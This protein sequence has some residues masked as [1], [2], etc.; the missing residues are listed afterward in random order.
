MPVT[1]PDD[2]NICQKWK[3]FCFLSQLALT[4]EILI[5]I[6]YWT[7]IYDRLKGTGNANEIDHTVPFIL[8]LIDYVF[9]QAVPFEW[10]HTLYVL[11]VGISYFLL[12]MTATLYA[13]RELY[14][15]VDFKSASGVALPFGLMFGGF[16]IYLV[17]IPI[18]KFKL[19]KLGYD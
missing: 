19:S 15:G 11:I 7:A 14:P 5:V 17:L 10:R 12:I 6:F 16:A 3:Q 8:I 1:T 18:N 2:P 13:G 4:I 9:F